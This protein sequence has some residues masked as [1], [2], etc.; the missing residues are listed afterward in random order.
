[1][2]MHF[3]LLFAD[4]GSVCLG[5]AVP[6]FFLIL[7]S[8]F[9]VFVRVLKL[10]LA[11]ASTG[12]RSVAQLTFILRQDVATKEFSS[13]LDEASSK[14]ACS[15]RREVDSSMRIDRVNQGWALDAIYILMTHGFLHLKALQDLARGKG[16]SYRL[17]IALGAIDDYLVL[18]NADASSSGLADQTLD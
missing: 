5:F 2:T 7:S 17:E 18:Y 8:H 12:R 3:N 13:I 14:T 16:L 4:I 1:M 10:V 9:N 6:T 11:I 15:S